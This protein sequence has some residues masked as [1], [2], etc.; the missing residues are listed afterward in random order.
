MSSY[1]NPAAIPFRLDVDFAVTTTGATFDI[2]N[3]SQ[4][5]G[6][7]VKDLPFHATGSTSRRAHGIVGR[8]VS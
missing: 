1:A 7:L 2:T 8:I 5:F 3:F 6:H 4:V